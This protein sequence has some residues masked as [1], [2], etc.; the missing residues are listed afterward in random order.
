MTA[1]WQLVILG[2]LAYVALGFLAQNP[3]SDVGR[4]AARFSH[5]AWIV[6]PL[7]AVLILAAMLLLGYWLLGIKPA[8]AASVLQGG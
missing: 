1:L 4:T 7:C 2:L 5:P 6:P 8:P 3:N